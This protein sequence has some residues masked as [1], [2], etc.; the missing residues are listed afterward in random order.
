[1][2]DKKERKEKKIGWVGI[3]NKLN[4]YGFGKGAWLW[5]EYILHNSPKIKWWKKSKNDA[6][7]AGCLLSIPEG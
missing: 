6:F 7:R 1:M 2:G 3:A 5:S 4:F